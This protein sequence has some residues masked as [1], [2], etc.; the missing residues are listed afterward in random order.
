MPI[1]YPFKYYCQLI[2]TVLTVWLSLLRNKSRRRSIYSPRKLR[3]RYRPRPCITML[4]I[5]DTMLYI[6]DT[7]LYIYYAVHI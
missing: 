4:Y 7:M 6:Y 2:N 3:L 5:Y 1:F